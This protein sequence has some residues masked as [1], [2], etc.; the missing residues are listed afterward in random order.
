MREILVMVAVGGL[1]AITGA[2]SADTVNV[3]SAGPGLGI[4]IPDDLYDGSFVG[5]ASDFIVVG[6][7]G[8][9]GNIITDIDV[10]IGMSHTWIGDLVIKLVSPGGTVLTLLSRP[11]F[12]ELADDGTGCCGDS[13]NLAFAF[14]ITYDDASLNSAELMGGGIGGTLVVGDPANGSPDNYFPNPGAGPGV[15]LSDFNGLNALG[16]WTLYIGDSVS[17][18]TGVLDRWSMTITTIPA[19]GALALLGMA[20]LVSRRRRRS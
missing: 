3:W 16:N 1:M 7:D 2:A 6:D 9:G 15:A 18:D 14:P 4:A 17:A 11:G 12:A 10:T 20:G 5:M 19:P 8:F 13:S